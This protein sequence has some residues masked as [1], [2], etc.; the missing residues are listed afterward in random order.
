MIQSCNGN[1]DTTRWLLELG[2]SADR[3]NERGQTPLMFAA[4]FGRGQVV[5]QLQA[6]GAS[7]RRRNR[8]GLSASFMVRVSGWIARL[9][10]SSRFQANHVP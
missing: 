1:A 5:A 4:M 6:H 2:S 9:F 3:R 8:L 7:L 10:R